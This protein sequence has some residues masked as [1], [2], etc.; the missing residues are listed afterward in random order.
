MAWT[1]VEAGV[2]E[3]APGPI[4]HDAGPTRASTW[5]AGGL[6]LPM[7]R[8]WLSVAEKPLARTTPGHHIAH[9][10]SAFEPR[11]VELS[12][13]PALAASGSGPIR[14]NATVRPP[15]RSSRWI[16]L[17]TVIAAFSTGTTATA[18]RR[19]TEST[20][21]DPPSSLSRARHSIAVR[22]S[23]MITVTKCSPRASTSAVGRS[24]SSEPRVSWSMA[25]H[26]SVNITTYTYSY[27]TGPDRQYH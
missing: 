26:A 3:A 7:T 18:D 20:V 16:T 5:P 2:G 8:S 12:P 14:P 1:S 22:S 13:N 15:G 17:A 6:A 11:T 21:A 19:S 4:H 9:Q 24:A 23:A 25:A 27:V 10:P